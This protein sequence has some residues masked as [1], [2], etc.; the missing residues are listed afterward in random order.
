[1]EPGEKY[2]PLSSHIAISGVQ[3]LYT[4][5]VFCVDWKR[6]TVKV[7][8]IWDLNL[9]GDLALTMAE[10]LR[11]SSILKPNTCK[12]TIMFNLPESTFSTKKISSRSVEEHRQY[13]E[14]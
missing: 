12:V 4:D 9:L 14:R 1:M 3:G 7:F 8:S 2:I 6:Q 11:L 5:V 10:I 13:I